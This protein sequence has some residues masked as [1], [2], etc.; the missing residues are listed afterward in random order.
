MSRQNFFKIYS[1]LPE[2]IRR[3][4]IIIV[5]QKPYS[6]N[7]CHSEIEKET[8]LGKEMLKKLEKMELI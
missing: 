6:W 8:D 2:D 3:E 7:A 5:N 4:I 1:N